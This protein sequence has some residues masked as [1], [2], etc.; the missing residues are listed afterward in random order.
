[1][2]PRMRIADR[3][4]ESGNYLRTYML[5]IVRSSWSWKF[6]SRNLKVG[7]FT[8]PKS[9]RLFL[10]SECIKIPALI[11]LNSRV[12]S[13]PLLTEICRSVFPLDIVVQQRHSNRPR[14]CSADSQNEQS[15]E[16][17]DERAVVCRVLSALFQLNFDY[18]WKVSKRSKLRSDPSS[19][20]WLPYCRMQTKQSNYDESKESSMK[21]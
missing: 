21:F 4:P 7:K 15:E 1:M 2:G 13:C 3:P 17:Q 5:V 19:A 8:S 11:W 9:K 18:S 6:R 14:N 20:C 16:H 10:H 12:Q